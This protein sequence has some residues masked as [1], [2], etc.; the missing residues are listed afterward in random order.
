M[1]IGYFPGCSL[2]GT[3]IEYNSSL[4]EVCKSFGYELEEIKDWNCCGATAAHSLSKLLSVALPA[5]TLA[6]AEKQGFTDILVPCAACYSRMLT[7]WHVIKIDAKLKKQIPEV[8]EM[9]Y[10]GTA[11]PMS[12]LDFISKYIA[13]ELKAKVINPLAKSV[14]CY[15]GCLLVRPNKLVNFDRYEDPT[16]MEGILKL[17]GAKPIDWAF[18]TECCGA[19]LSVPRT[20]IVAKLSGKIL[21]DATHRGAEAIIAACPMCQ[22][23]LDMRR[24]SIN[25]YLGT[26]N[27]VPVLYI[28]EAIGL[29]IGIDKDK[30]GTGKH[31]VKTNNFITHINI[32]KEK[33][34]MA[35]A[36]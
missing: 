36:V 4:L 22:S 19:G 34:A 2:H 10:H 29:A 7:A 15:Y 26:E 24:K 9:E 6:L 16:V 25:K 20:D 1:K 21:E 5:R 3:A 12:I 35:E 23:N 14:A 8:I 17:L 31:F 13:P 28:T 32:I 11:K 30:L 33:Q 27:D 18:K